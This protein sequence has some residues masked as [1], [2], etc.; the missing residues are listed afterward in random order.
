MSF[1]RVRLVN[2]VKEKDHMLKIEAI[3]EIITR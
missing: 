1:D 2:R 3:L